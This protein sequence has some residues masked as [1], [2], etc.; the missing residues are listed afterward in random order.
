M[1][2]FNFFSLF[3]QLMRF[4]FHFFHN[5]ELLNLI[6]KQELLN[7]NKREAGCGHMYV[8]CGAVAVNMLKKVQ[9]HSVNIFLQAAYLVVD[10]VTYL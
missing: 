8:V 9:A 2:D 10:A 3:S 5:F 1:L 4:T 7:P 6:M